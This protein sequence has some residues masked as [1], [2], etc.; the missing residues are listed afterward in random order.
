MN[1]DG[2]VLLFVQM[3]I[4][5]F[6][7][8]P[9]TCTCVCVCVCVLAYAWVRSQTNIPMY[10]SYWKFKQVTTYSRNIHFRYFYQSSVAVFNPKWV[11]F[12][13]LRFYFGYH[14]T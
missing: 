6:K 8:T 11:R 4:S 10:A 12:S 5:L 14:M 1:K 3:I 9:C 2:V 7:S 13:W